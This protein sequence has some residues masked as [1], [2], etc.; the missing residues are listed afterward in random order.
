LNLKLLIENKLLP[1]RKKLANELDKAK[2]NLEEEKKETEQMLRQNKHLRRK[3]QTEKMHNEEE[4]HEIRIL[5][6][7]TKDLEEEAEL[8]AQDIDETTQVVR[9]IKRENMDLE[10]E[11]KTVE[12]DI[13]DELEN[14]EKVLNEIENKFGSSVDDLQKKHL[15][16]TK[17][18]AQ[19][20]EAIAQEV[21]LLG[22]TLEA[23]KKNYQFSGS[24][25]S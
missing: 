16:A 4:V 12:D 8:K 5:E 2:K 7:Q 23:K 19:Q 15:R 17:K 9:A 25:N 18:I 21:E 11:R 20:K 1:Q 22:D 14:K 3:V 10:N 13:G 24:V 6:A